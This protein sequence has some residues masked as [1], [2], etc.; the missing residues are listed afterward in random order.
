MAASKANPRKKAAA[1]G[2]PRKP[3][4]APNT[5]ARRKATARGKVADKANKAAKKAKAI[6]ATGRHLGAVK[7]SYRDS[8][9]VARV[10]QGVRYDVIAAEMK[11]SVRTVEA[12]VAATRKVRSPLERT[13]GELLEDLA[14]GFEL[15]IGDFEAMAALYVEGSPSDAIRAKRAANEARRAHAEVMRAVGKLPVDLELFR[16]ELEMKR[17]AA[18][19][20]EKMEAVVAGDVSAEEAWEFFRGIVESPSDAVDST[21]VELPPGD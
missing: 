15:S 9:I 18:L 1:D 21:A 14:R 8:A 5:K 7:Q 4:S 17:L 12:V 16:S 20:R 11:V 2:K 3:R 6:G 19:M 13:P 10:A